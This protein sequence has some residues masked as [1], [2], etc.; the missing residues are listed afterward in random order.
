[1]EI[2]VSTVLVSVMLVGMINIFFAGRRYIQRSRLRMAGGELGRVF[3]E[4]LQNS[5]RQDAWASGCLGSDGV[6]GCPPVILSQGSVTYTPDYTI[7]TVQVG[8]VDTTLKKV[9]LTIQYHENQP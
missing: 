4:P 2:L 8:G 7:T 5:V 3:L 9:N 6:L 1:M